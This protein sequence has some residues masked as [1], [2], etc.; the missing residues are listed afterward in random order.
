MG[1]LKVLPEKIKE[2]I[3]KIQAIQTDDL[4]S[5]EKDL[6]FSEKVCFL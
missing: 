2:N 5:L 3:Q 4:I 1:D 6:D